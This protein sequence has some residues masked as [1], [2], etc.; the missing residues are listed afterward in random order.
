MYLST[1][2]ALDSGERNERGGIENV[3]CSVYSR[4]DKDDCFLF[5]Q[6]VTNTN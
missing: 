5:F 2:S 4:I 3:S 6:V 1:L